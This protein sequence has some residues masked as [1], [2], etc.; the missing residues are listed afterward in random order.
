MLKKIL[1]TVAALAGIAIGGSA[2]WILHYVLDANAS[3]ITG[4]NVL[5]AL[6]GTLGLLF[7]A[8][9]VHDIKIQKPRTYGLLALGIAC[10]IFLQAIVY[11][12]NPCPDDCHTDFVLK[13]GVC[14]ILM[15]DG[16]SSLYRKPA[17]QTIEKP[18]G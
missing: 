3:F 14:V 11:F 5:T 9:I 17:E 4:H 18:A 15:V 6:V 8:H 16:F 10:G 2:A 1:L 13:L 7:F 12:K